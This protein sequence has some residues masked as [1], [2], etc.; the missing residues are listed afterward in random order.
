M[1]KPN[2]RANF[3]FSFSNDVDNT[4]LQA[5]TLVKSANNFTSLSLMVT[6]LIVFLLTSLLAS[7]Y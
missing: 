7:V 3:S 2:R 4:T 6:I 1:S 5:R